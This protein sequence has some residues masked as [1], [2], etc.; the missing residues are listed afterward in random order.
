MASGRAARAG[1]EARRAG[2]PVPRRPHG[3][4]VTGA[5]FHDRW[6]EWADGRRGVEAEGQARIASA[7]GL[8]RLA[9]LT[10]RG[11][12]QSGPRLQPGRGA[13]SPTRAAR[14]TRYSA[15][16]LVRPDGAGDHQLVRRNGGGSVSWTPDGRPSSSTS[17]APPALL[18]TCSRPAGGGRGGPARAPAH[19]GR[20]RPAIRTCRRTAARVVFVRQLADRS[21][22]ARWAWTGGSRGTSRGPSRARSGAARAGAPRGTRSRRRAGWPAAG[23]TWCC[24][25]PATG[26]V[27]PLTDDRAKDVE[28]AWTPDGSARRLPLRPGRGLEPLRVRLADRSARAGDQRARAAPSTRTVS[29]DGDAVAFASYAPADTTSTSAALDLPAAPRRGAFRGPL[30]ARRRLTVARRTCPD[31]P[32]GPL[33]R[34]RPRFWTPYWSRNA[35]ECEWGPPRRGA[36]P[37]SATTTA[38]RPPGARRRDRLSVQGFYQYDRCWPTFLVVGRRT[39]PSSEGG[40]WA[41]ADAAGDASP[42]GGRMR[43]SQSLSLA[44]RREPRGGEG[45]GPTASTSAAWRPPGPF[46][47][48]RQYPYSISPVEACAC[49]WP[50]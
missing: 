46:C 39:T 36:I 24:V 9:P 10:A 48:A 6:R 47:S 12:R 23:W 49:A 8:T 34:L 14:L 42:S 2:D 7:R 32:T 25:D 38:S 40:A 50:T 22:L 41:G 30:S 28:P 44:W 27:T 1:P 3:Q 18:S 13:G 29:P 45:A 5:T 26:A 15:I 31:R 11:V 4:K 43:S 33:P 37:C 17:R 35:D 16:R 19:P 21:E 20:A